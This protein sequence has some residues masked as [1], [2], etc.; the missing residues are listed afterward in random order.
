M[1]SINCSKSTS[2]AI[3][4][5]SASL[6]L[7]NEVYIL[8]H[9]LSGPKHIRVKI[10]PFILIWFYGKVTTRLGILINSDSSMSRFA[11]RNGKK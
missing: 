9:I 5:I 7:G 2:N 11:V 8:G 10:D 4:S 3:K 1:L 6:S